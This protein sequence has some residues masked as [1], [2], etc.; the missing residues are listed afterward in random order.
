[1]ARFESFIDYVFQVRRMA[2]TS[3]P[4]CLA[5]LLNSAALLYAPL[6]SCP[7]MRT[8]RSSHLH[9]PPRPRQK[10]PC[11]LFHVHRQSGC[12]RPPAQT[13]SPFQ[14]K[15]SRLLDSFLSKVC[16]VQCLLT[17]LRRCIKPVSHIDQLLTF[18]KLSVFLWSLFLQ[19]RVIRV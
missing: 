14:R 10:F 6:V 7:S 12:K 19:N 2:V 4:L 18:N 8:R 11:L 13:R 16:S 9:V 5:L 1:M 15:S 3:R 17:S